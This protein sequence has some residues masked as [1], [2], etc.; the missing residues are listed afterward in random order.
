MNYG[1]MHDRVQSFQ[2][3]GVI[4]HL[5]GE[6]LPIDVAIGGQDIGA[7]LLQHR[8]VRR[9]SLRQALMSELVGMDQQASHSL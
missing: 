5:R 9:S 6:G 8:L 7:E 1:W 3:L 4:E 2:T